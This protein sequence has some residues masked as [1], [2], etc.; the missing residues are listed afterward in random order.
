MSLFDDALVEKLLQNLLACYVCAL[1]YFLTCAFC[2]WP[3]P[4]LHS[5]FPLSHWSLFSRHYNTTRTSNCLSNLSP[6]P[7]G[8]PRE[9]QQRAAYGQGLLPG[10]LPPGGRHF[11][12][13]DH[14][15]RPRLCGHTVEPHELFSGTIGWGSLD[16][17]WLTLIIFKKYSCEAAESL[18]EDWF[19]FFAATV[20]PGVDFCCPPP[21][22]PASI[23]FDWQVKSDRPVMNCLFLC[24]SGG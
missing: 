12:R 18:Y 22:P 3:L 13:Q 20:N 5:H 2:P 21:P 4:S 16:E 6:T 1:I 24:L 11:L 19:L 7:Q 10:S 14:P 9:R 8:R 23:K 17:Y 15:Q